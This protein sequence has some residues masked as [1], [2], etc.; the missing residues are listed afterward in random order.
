M[1]KFENVLQRLR[2]EQ[3]QAQAAVENLGKAI[4]AIEG[5]NGTGAG[6]NKDVHD[7]VSYGKGR[8]LADSGFVQTSFDAW[9]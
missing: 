8:L 2:A 1:T 6:S 5:Q 9:T 3:K 4:S 7:S